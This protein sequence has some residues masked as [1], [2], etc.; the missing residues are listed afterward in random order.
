MARKRT[1]AARNVS[2]RVADDFTRIDGIGPITMKRLHS[3]RIYTFAQLAA[4]SAEGITSL[5]PSLSTKQIL[6]QS[7]IQQ[8]REL[9]SSKAASKTLENEPSISASRQHYENF[10]LEFL[11][12]EK[13][14]VRRLQIVHIQSGDVDTLTKWDAERLIDFLARHT[15]VRLPY[16]KSIVLTTQKVHPPLKPSTSSEQPSEVAT[17][18]VSIAPIGRTEENIDLSPSLEFIESTV[19][20]LAPADQLPSGG[21]PQ[22]V[23]SPAVSASTI[24]KIRLLEWKIFLSSTKQILH[25]LHHDQCFDVNLTLDLANASLPSTSQLDFNVSIYAKKLGDGP[26]RLIGETQKTMPYAEVVDL[27]VG[28]ASL[29]QGLYRL[30]AFVTL[31]PTDASLS[32]KPDINIP[33]QGGLLQLY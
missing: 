31:V 21:V 7:W 5:I 6:N 25:N 17:K 23:S 4:L 26:R 33:V 29:P 12:S 32:T 3:S 24:S 9:A 1:H 15:S 16:A 8:A 28:N 14:K 18:T 19:P 13:N 10:T 22:Q 2:S 20:V 11:L 27:T 30:E